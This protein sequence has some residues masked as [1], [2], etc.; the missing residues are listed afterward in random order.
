MLVNEGIW[1]RFV[2][3]AAEVHGA[4]TRCGLEKVPVPFGWPEDPNVRFAVAVVVA[5]NRRVSVCAKLDG[6]VVLCRNTGRLCY[7]KDKLGVA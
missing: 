7:V 6:I 5:R 1:R 4:E 3:R 2:F